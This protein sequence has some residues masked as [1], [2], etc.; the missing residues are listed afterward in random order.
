MLIGFELHVGQIKLFACF[1]LFNFFWDRGTI[2][3]R[4]F[5]RVQ[6]HTQIKPNEYVPDFRKCSIETI[7][8]M[9]PAHEI[10]VAYLSHRREA[11]AQLIVRICSN[12]FEPC[13]VHTIIK[14][15]RKLSSLVF[16]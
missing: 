16:M 7:I 2:I 3:F 4:T 1:Y 9:G 15:A 10:F 8:N 12:S 14:E 5:I 13:A 11:K 6:T